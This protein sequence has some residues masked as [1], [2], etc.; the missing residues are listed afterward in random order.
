MNTFFFGLLLILA[1]GLLPLLLSRWL[2]TM[3][4]IGIATSVAG[5]LLGLIAAARVILTG[6]TIAI[7]L[8]LTLPGASFAIMVDP[9]AAFFLAPLFLI[10]LLGVIYGS[11]YMASADGL[12]M[13]RHYF[14]YN[15]LVLSMALVV[16]SANAMLFLFAWEC[17]SLTS[18]FLVISD[19]QEKQVCRAGF[20]YL[21]A[22]HLGAMALFALFL[23]AGA[24][25][26]S[27]DF[28]TFHALH[29]L[30]PLPA[31]ILFLLAL[32]GFGSK[33]GLFP[34]HVWLPEAH[35]AAPSHVSALM[36]AVMVK[37]AIYA[38][39]RFLSFLPPAS[40]WWGGLMLTLGIAGGL[41]G[42]GM[43][44]TQKDLKRSLAYSTV[45][46]VGLI[47]LALGFWLYATATNHSLPAV[48]ALTGGL[49]HLWN[50]CLFKSLLFMGAGSILHGAGT[51]NLNQMGGLLRRMPYTG[52]LMIIGA[53][54]V[55]ALPP[56]NGLVGEWFIYRGLLEGGIKFQG[57]AASLPIVLVGLMAMIGAMVLLVMVRIIGIGLSGEPR[58]QN[59]ATAHESNQCMISSMAVLAIICLA[60]GLFPA[61]LINPVV[62]VAGM[63]SPGA[64]SLLHTSGHLPYWI[65][66][67]GIGIVFLALVIFTGVQ[68]LM[69]RWKGAAPT[70]GCG[71]PFPSAR[72]SYSAEGFNELAQN[73]FYCDCLC[74]EVNGGEPTALLPGRAVFAHNAGDFFLQAVYLPLFQTAAGFCSRM[75]RLQSG[76]LQIYIFYVFCTLILLLGWLA[77]N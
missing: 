7:S 59:A 60:G 71:F 40:A 19:H 34:F 20:T 56:L 16:S 27:L 11:G 55:S 8:P 70:W 31:G 36:S 37:T 6:Q 46:N 4:I 24:K 43:A 30:S 26:G 67:L 39:L 58:C 50:H 49:M 57:L 41:F 35:P 61:L 12:E 77:L 54:A 15:L 65:G 53:L 17:M 76:L 10:S 51:R 64:D 68:L 75:R 32:G 63:I 45:E 18:F 42:I 38:L 21:L 52:L 5:S 25:S 44:A 9:L 72:M 3:K 2:N 73:S 74:P 29:D 62:A 66:G 33:A 1:G 28:A 69:P 13:G 48:L 47:F 14:F 23:L 22:T